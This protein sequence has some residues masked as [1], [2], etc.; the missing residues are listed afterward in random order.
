MNDANMICQKAN[1]DLYKQTED[2]ERTN[3]NVK[4]IGGKLGKSSGL[5][6]LIKKNKNRQKLIYCIA[7]CF[8]IFL[9]ILVLVLKFR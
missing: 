8:G 2:L 7:I 1:V 3:Q 4:K 9:V 5:L 6:Y